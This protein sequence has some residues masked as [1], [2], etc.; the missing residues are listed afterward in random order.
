MNKKSL[1]KKKSNGKKGILRNNINQ[2]NFANHTISSAIKADYALPDVKY[3]LDELNTSVKKTR[4]VKTA[5]SV[6][7]ARKSSSKS[8]KPFVVRKVRLIIYLLA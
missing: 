4:I 6:N 7:K 3:K 1:L 8:Q 2:E 5:P